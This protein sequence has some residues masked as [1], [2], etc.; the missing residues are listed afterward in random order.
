MPTAT[1]AVSKTVMAPQPTQKM[2]KFNW[3]KI[4][5]TRSP[6]SM[7]GPLYY[8]RAQLTQEEKVIIP[9]YERIEEHF[10]TKVFKPKG[11]ESAAAPKGHHKVEE[12]ELLDSKRSQQLGMF[13]GSLHMDWHLLI[14]AIVEIDFDL[15]KP[16]KALLLQSAMP[17]PE[18]VKL[19]KEKGAKILANTAEDAPRLSN[20]DKFIMALIDINGYHMLVDTIVLFEQFKG[21]FK[22]VSEPAQAL[23]A[24]FTALRD[25]DQLESL[26]L[27]IL[28]AGNFINAADHRNSNAVGFALETL[29][30]MRDVKSVL[31]SSALIHRMVEDVKD[32]HEAIFNFVD[33]LVN[34][35]SKLPA[36]FGIAEITS[37]SHKLKLK[38]KQLDHKSETYRHDGDGGWGTVF[39]EFFDEAIN[40]MEEQEVLLTKTEEC[41]HVLREMFTEEDEAVILTTWKDFLSDLVAADMENAAR[42]EKARKAA[43]RE[44]E[45]ERQEAIQENILKQA[46]ARNPDEEEVT[47]T[48][49]DWDAIPASSK[50]TTV[51][52]DET[53]SQSPS[54]KNDSQDDPNATTNKTFSSNDNNNA[55][56]PFS[57]NDNNNADDPD[58][59]V[60]SSPEKT[61]RRLP[62]PPSPQK[63]PKVGETKTAANNDDN[64][65]A[66]I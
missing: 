53:R 55:D 27:Y 41:V 51:V 24:A 31:D 9:D 45:K 6:Q 48:D 32:Q 7:F 65:Q 52:E 19:F 10:H 54:P 35:F 2:K 50:S 3:K 5:F 56:D 26:L 46:E 34:Q 33:K 30:K 18:E 42:V 15:L 39:D 36:S 1:V 37:D 21:D 8:K 16:E 63:E 62:P 17:L 23:F 20:G 38:V 66:W 13:L 40:S 29:T 59:A 64:D 11:S 22:R 25:S 47:T 12:M 57:S 44:A 60:A 14:K 28:D 43:A 49:A 61:V 4:N 58:E